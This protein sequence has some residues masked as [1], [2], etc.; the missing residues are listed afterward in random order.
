M[1]AIGE[2]IDV[3]AYRTAAALLPRLLGVIYFFCFGAFLFQIKGLLGKNGI[4]PIEAFLKYISIRIPGKKRYYYLPTLFW[5]NA[6]D[7]MLMAVA[8]TGTVISLLLV[9][10][11]YPPLMLILLYLLHLSLLTA[12]QDFLSFGWETFLLEITFN[13]FFLSLT[14]TPNP[15]IWI[16]LNLLLFR[17]HFQAGVSKFLSKDET[18]RDLTAISYHYQTQPL[19]NT[20]A[21]YIHKFPMWFHK[22]STALMFFIELVVPLGIFA[23]QEIRFF[24]FACFVGLQFFIWLTGNFSY[25][26]H[27]AVA[28]SII[29]I[30]DQYFENWLG[31]TPPPESSSPLILDVLISTVGA[32]LIFLQVISLWHYFSFNATFM[33]ILNWVSPFHIAN[34]YGIFA[35]MTTKRYEIVVEGSDDQKEWREYHFRYKPTELDH[36]PRRISPYQPR[37]DWQ[38]WF[39]P[40]SS[41]QMNEWFQNFLFR[42]LQGSPE[43]L[44]LLRHNPFPDKPPKYIRAIAYDYQFS[45]RTTKK[46]TGVWWKRHYAGIYCPTIMLK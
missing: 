20:I 10:N 41:Y 9:F 13:T 16:S 17:F 42:L 40:F 36:R 14:V 29:L 26:N 44:K 21:W 1:D 7:G 19:P 18:W 30:S 43:V 24:V 25:L 11:I 34:R 35:V 23:T 2:W 8:G 22:L 32:L 31:L 15:F 39:L 37:L 45:D 12:G 3:G 46:L 28:F 38:M 5:L 27:L 6:S 33:K 4:M